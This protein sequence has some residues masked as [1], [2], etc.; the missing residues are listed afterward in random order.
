MTEEDRRDLV[1]LNR[2]DELLQ[3][4]QGDI[5]AKITVITRSLQKRRHP[6]DILQEAL[7]Q[8]IRSER[9]RQAQEE[10]LWIVNLKK[11]LVGDVSNLSSDEAKTC[12]KISPDYEIG[13]NDLLFFCPIAKR[14]TEDREGLVRLVIVEKLQQDFLR[15]YHAR[16]EGGHQGISRTYQRIRSRSTGEDYIGAY[17]CTLGECT[18]CETVKGCPMIQGKSPGNLQATYP[19]QIIAVDHI[20]SLPKSCKGNT[21]LLIWVDLFSGYV[22]A[23]ACSSRTAQTIAGNYEEFVFRRFGKSEAIRHDREPGFM[24]DFFR[25]FNRIVGQVQW[26]IDPKPT[27]RQN[28]WCKR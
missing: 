10:K 26:H 21:E 16:L 2:L 18:D 11:Y 17:R 12:A 4:R 6:P 7:V 1:T 28:V 22:I 24:S 25:V 27:E 20:P 13:E 14:E 3:P 9:I 23:R 15:H 19:F 8:R 5:I